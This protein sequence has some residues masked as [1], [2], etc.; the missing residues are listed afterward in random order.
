VT[1]LEL[2]T[3]MRLRNY[4]R[5]LQQRFDHQNLEFE[6]SIWHVS[7]TYLVL[8]KFHELCCEF[9][10]LVHILEE[11]G[12]N[13]P[14]GLGTAEPPGT[15]GPVGAA[16]LAGAAGPTPWHML[17]P[18]HLLSCEH[19]LDKRD[20]PRKHWFDRM[21]EVRITWING[22]TCPAVQPPQPS[23]GN[24]RRPWAMAVHHTAQR[25]ASRTSQPSCRAKLT[26]GNDPQPPQ[27]QWSE[28]SKER[29]SGSQGRP[30]P[31]IR[32]HLWYWAHT[33]NRPPLHIKGT[34]HSLDWTHNAGASPFSTFVHL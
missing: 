20:P 3:N 28:A 24:P 14:H 27:E 10:R 17:S 26:Q 1:L 32:P 15:T 25:R 6:R 31:L 11:I 8:I 22:S 21:D 2:H 12:S 30:H 9:H 7:C 16:G 33:L 18:M 19:N 4:W 29:G 5:S 23:Q 13:M 34:S